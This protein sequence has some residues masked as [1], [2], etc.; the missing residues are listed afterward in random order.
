MTPALLPRGLFAALARRYQERLKVPLVAPGSFCPY[1]TQMRVKFSDNLNEFAP[2]GGRLAAKRSGGSG[3]SRFS[4]S[5]PLSSRSIA[6]RA[7]RK[8][9]VHHP[10]KIVAPS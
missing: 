9:I 7:R 1:S 8:P 4:T 10:G 6:R 3:I 5:P 2:G